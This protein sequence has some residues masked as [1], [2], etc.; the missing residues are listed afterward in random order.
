MSLLILTLPPLLVMSMPR[1]ACWSGYQGKIYNEKIRNMVWEN[2]AIDKSYMH[3]L[4]SFK[5]ARW[6]DYSTFDRR[7]RSDACHH[8]PE[9]REKMTAKCNMT[10]LLGRVGWSQV[11]WWFYQG[12]R[13]KRMFCG[14]PYRLIWGCKI[15]LTCHNISKSDSFSLK[16]RRRPT[17]TDLIRSHQ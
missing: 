13:L 7:R 11:L 8:L 14:G 10:K 2:K 4:S 3:V 1:P 16:T 17:P 9:V 12:Y 6:A 15:V 5:C